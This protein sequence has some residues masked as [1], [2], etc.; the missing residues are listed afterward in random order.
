MYI[1]IDHGTNAI[2]FAGLFINENKKSSLMHIH[3]KCDN[4]KLNIQFELEKNIVSEM[5]DSEILQHIKS[6]FNISLEEIELIAITYSMGDAITEITDI[7]LLD[8]RGVKNI[9]GVGEK[10]GAGT[11]VFDAIKN[12]KIPTIVIP[13]IHKES[14]T[15][16][17]MN[18]FSHSTSPEKIGIAYHAKCKRLSK[19]FIVSDIGSNTVTVGCVDGKIIGAIDACIF[20]PGTIHGP[21]DVEAI[22]LID[23]GE[24]SAND[25]FINAGVLKHTPYKTVK[26]LLVGIEKKEKSGIFAIESIALFAAMEISSM[27]V[28]L[29]DYGA[30]NIDIFLTGSMGELKFTKNKID[31]HLNVKTY[32]IDKMSAAIGCAEIA[33]DVMNGQNEIL[34]IRVNFKI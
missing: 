30:K 9:E 23:K 34:G 6:N 11:R 22:R 18:V 4:E 10:T 27:I 3:S 29:M 13:G 19:D 7:N 17:R 12:S 24:L 32:V 33:R 16:A 8:S 2:R 31:K 1:G 26:D 15:D 14:D 28:L 25:A 20:A 5:N 21:L